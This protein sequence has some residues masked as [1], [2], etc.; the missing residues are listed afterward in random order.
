MRVVDEGANEELGVGHCRS[1]MPLPALIRCSTA[2]TTPLHL[3]P[4]PNH[5]HV[6]P[7]PCRAWPRLQLLP[8]SL[9]STA[10]R[11]ALAD[12]LGELSRAGRG[13]LFGSVGGGG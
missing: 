10:H 1:L 7:H 11:L 2:T 9:S 8:A 3:L 6:F 12:L 13:A 4:P 5:L